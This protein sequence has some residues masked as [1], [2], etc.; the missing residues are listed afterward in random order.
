M[1]PVYP[2]EKSADQAEDGTL[3]AGV[4]GAEKQEGHVALLTS[5][6]C[7]V[8]AVEPWT[9]CSSAFPSGVDQS[10]CSLAP[11]PVLGMWPPVSLFPVHMAPL[12]HRHPAGRSPLTSV[13][14]QGEAPAVERVHTLE[15]RVGQPWVPQPCHLSESVCTL[16]E[17]GWDLSPCCTP[18]VGAEHRALIGCIWEVG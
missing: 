18:R 15:Q 11:H 4:N 14:V 8:L 1:C 12:E 10:S 3:P 17:G 6:P 7:S 5:W 13:F 2:P 16:T 9:R